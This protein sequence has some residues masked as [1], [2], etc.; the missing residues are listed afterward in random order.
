MDSSFTVPFIGRFLDP[1]LEKGWEQN[2]EWA[3]REIEK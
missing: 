3:K 2:I 1:L